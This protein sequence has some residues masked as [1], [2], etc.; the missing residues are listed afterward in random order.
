MKNKNKRVDFPTNMEIINIL[1]FIIS[2]II[3]SITG[4]FWL[5]PIALGIIFTI[6]I[7]ILRKMRKQSKELKGN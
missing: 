7:F 4:M 3:I 1:I 5:I 2:I 6:M